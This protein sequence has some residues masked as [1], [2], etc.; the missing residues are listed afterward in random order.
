MIFFAVAFP[1]AGTALLG[2]FGRMMPR[3][4]AG[5]LACSTI[6]LSFLAALGTFMV[7]LYA[8]GSTTSPYGAE[9]V[10]LAPWLTIPGFEV[11]LSF[12]VDALSLVMALT[13][14]FV[15]FFIHVYSLGYMAHDDGYARYFAYLNLFVAM[16]L[17]LVLA[18]NLL[19]AFIGWEGVG[20]CSYLLIGF[21]YKKP[22]PPLAG[23]KAFLVNRIGDFGFILG[24]LILFWLLGTVDFVGMRMRLSG[25]Q[26]DLPLVLTA[27]ALL[28]FMGAMGKSA[29]FPLHVW[30]PDA[31]EGPTPVS[32][33]IH[34]A[35]MVTAGVYL[36]ARMS[37][38]FS[39]SQPAMLVMACVGAFTAIFAAS[40]ALVQNDI[41]RVLAYSTVSQLGYMFLAAGLG[42][43]WIAIFHLFTHAFFK[44]LLFLGSGSVIHALDGEQDMRKMGGLAKAM[45]QTYWQFLIG[46]MAISGVPL[47]SGFFSKDE[48]LFGALTARNA[49]FPQAGIILFAVGALTA[50]LTAFYM[51]RQVQLVFLTPPRWDEGVHPHEAPPSMRLP[52][53]VLAAGS[54]LAGYIGLP[55]LFTAFLHVPN[56]LEQ[57]LAP[58]LPGGHAIVREGYEGMLMAR[59]AGVEAISAVIALAGIWLAFYLYRERT[60]ITA[61]LKRAFAGPYKLLLNKYYIDEFYSGAIVEPGKELTVQLSRYVD[62]GFIDGAVNGAAWFIGALG[63]VL[64]PLQTGFIRNYAWYISVGVVL[65]IAMLWA[66][67]WG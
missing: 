31:M 18:S 27:A 47:L 8:N 15:S 48:I 21:W 58:A 24:T 50:L 10:T 17:T 62:T 33:L 14:T 1:L 60:G 3:K 35:T 29:Q 65:V 57:F 40:I 7:F 53:W 23:M 36:A 2:F 13:V 43:Y 34:A 19:V 16:M 61:M 52:C 12:Q 30:L 41:K 45:P 9:I 32:A 54:V 51:F 64:R 42:A 49:L 44:A 4:V 59:E 55:A 25:A 20:L 6:L 56:L 38:L 28:L 22:A 39:L 63:Q 66:R 37:F 46:A 67:G 26:H 5:A 11:N